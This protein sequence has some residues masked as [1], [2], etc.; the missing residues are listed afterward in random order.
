[1]QVRLTLNRH[2]GRPHLEG[3]PGALG[4]L[5]EQ[6]APHG[7][8]RASSGN[9]ELA[10]LAKLDKDARA[11]WRRLGRVADVSAPRIRSSPAERLPSP[12]SGRAFVRAMAAARESRK[13]ARG[14]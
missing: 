13:V 3:R 11:A 7:G 9:S 5:D 10:P 2:P 1:T 8:E 4:Q 6:A 14:A 12:A